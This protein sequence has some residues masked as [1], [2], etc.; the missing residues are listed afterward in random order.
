MFLKE[1]ESLAS[2]AVYAATAKCS[3]PESAR[4]SRS[5]GRSAFSGV[6]SWAEALELA[7]T[8][9]PEECEQ[10]QALTA[11]LFSAVADRMV[12]PEVVTDVAGD[13]IDMGSYCEGKPDCWLATQQSDELTLGAQTVTVVADVCVSAGNLEG[14][15]LHPGCGAGGAR[16]GAR[17]RWTRSS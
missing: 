2:L 8:G 7:R 5:I 1:F 3:M 13:M 16:G 9:W 6:E 10:I 15:D 14:D 12:R 4:S 11:P 17:V